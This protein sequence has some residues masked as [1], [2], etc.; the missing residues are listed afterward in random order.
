[1]MRNHLSNRLPM[2]KK[3]LQSANLHL[4]AECNRGVLALKG[5]GLMNQRKGSCDVIQKPLEF[6]YPQSLLCAIVLS[7]LSTLRQNAYKN[8][9]TPN[10]LCSETVDKSI[11]LKQRQKKALASNPPC[12]VMHS[13]MIQPIEKRTVQHYSRLL[14][15]SHKGAQTD[16]YARHN[17]DATQH[18]AIYLNLDTGS[19]TVSCQIIYA[20]GLHSPSI[21]RTGFQIH[22]SIEKKQR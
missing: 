2:K 20:R 6:K 11:E 7:S 3:Q 4:C 13:G 21:I 15:S 14:P 1:M 16:P 9:A 5:R 8:R 22:A 12:R 10:A 18:L 17:Y 19:L